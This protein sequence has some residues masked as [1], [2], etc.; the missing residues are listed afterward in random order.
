MKKYILSIAFVFISLFSFSQ[1]SEYYCSKITMGYWNRTSRKWD[2]D[3]GKKVNLKLKIYKNVTT[4]DD[5]AQSRYEAI[6]GGDKEDNSTYEGMTWNGVDE[7]GRNILIKI[8][9]YKQSQQKIYMVIYDDML[10]IY[11]ISESRLSPFNS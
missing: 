4:I 10:F 5:E 11:N 1:A 2:Y 3:D 7:K 8:I 9:Y 6:S